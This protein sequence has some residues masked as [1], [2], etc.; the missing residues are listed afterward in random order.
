MKVG[1]RQLLGWGLA[2]AGV[3]GAT[4]LPYLLRRR[5]AVRIPPASGAAEVSAFNPMALLRQFDYGTLKQENGTRVREFRIEARTGRVQLNPALSFI[6]WN[7]GGRIPG[8]TLRA[9]AGE[10]VRVL[11]V[12]HGGHA[13]TMHFH[14]VHSGA[15]DGI[16]PVRDG[17]ATIYEFDAEPFGVHLYHCHISP[18]A[19]HISKGLYGMFIVDPPDGRAPADEMVLVMGGFDLY[20][21][22]RN[23]IYAFNGIPNYYL[24]HPIRIYQDQLVRLYLLNM[25]EW[26]PALTFHLHANFFRLLRTGRTLEATEEADVV[27]MGT[28]ERHILEFSYRY[29]GAYMFHPHQDVVAEN[30]CMGQFLVLPADGTAPAAIDTGHAHS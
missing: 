24:Q 26:Q 16:R 8:P 29:P 30:G 19:R 22:G 27:T 11:F 10:R 2:G 18:V 6:S 4:A 23:D 3:A 9:Q 7:F 28:A 14:G 13:H 25:V 20:D 21:R 17:A 15:M 12:N 1:R 5:S